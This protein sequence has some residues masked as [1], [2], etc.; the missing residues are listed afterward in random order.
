MEGASLHSE[1]VEDPSLALRMTSGRTFDFNPFF[2]IF[3][4]YYY[5]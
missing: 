2:F 5:Y 3:V 1:S 4:H